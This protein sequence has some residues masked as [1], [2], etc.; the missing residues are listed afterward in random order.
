MPLTGKQRRELMARSHALKPSLIVTE[1]VSPS[2][3]T[4]LRQLLEKQDLVKV[5]LATEDRDECDAWAAELAESVQSE[6]VRRTG[7]I[8]IYYRTPAPTAD[9]RDVN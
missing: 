9:E 7:R 5:R 4:H 8:A 3:C 1:G 2:I 6:L